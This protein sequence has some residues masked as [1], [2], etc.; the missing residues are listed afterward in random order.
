M[1]G[2]QL[3]D[4]F[5]SAFNG[6]ANR[7]LDDEEPLEESVAAELITIQRSNISTEKSYP[8]SIEGRQDVLI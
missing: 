6:E 1:T 2:C 5:E 3:K 4:K 7:A 8:A